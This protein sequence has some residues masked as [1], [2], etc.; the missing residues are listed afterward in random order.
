MIFPSN[1]FVPSPLTKKIPNLLD[2]KQAIL[3]AIPTY[4]LNKDS[5]TDADVQYIIDH[6]IP[7]YI[8][9][10][11]SIFDGSITNPYPIYE[12][13]L[14]QRSSE[15][16]PLN[17]YIFSTFAVPPLNKWVCLDAL[18]DINGS[19]DIILRKRTYGSLR[20]D[21]KVLPL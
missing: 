2:R 17:N 19:I 3:N 9:V 8:S 4:Q 15:W 11:K 7:S 20:E 6:T 18:M 12:D 14:V 21:K 1:A 10:L 5:F 13:I 16:I